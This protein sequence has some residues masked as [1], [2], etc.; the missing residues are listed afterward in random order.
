MTTRG[1]KEPEMIKIA[2]MITAVLRD[3]KNEKTIEQVRRQAR[4]LCQQFPLYPD[5]A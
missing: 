1:M 2:D 4:E 3:I 5:L